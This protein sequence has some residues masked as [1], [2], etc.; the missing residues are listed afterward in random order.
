[1]RNKHYYNGRGKSPDRNTM[2]LV[3]SAMSK[4]QLQQEANYLRSQST[5]EECNFLLEPE[6]R[7]KTVENKKTG[8]LKIVHFKVG[9]KCKQPAIVTSRCPQTNA[10]LHRCAAHVGCDIQ[11][12]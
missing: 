9:K 3:P 5:Y 7:S 11:Q 8:E 4:K 12:S 1:M 2:W 10:R 6:Q